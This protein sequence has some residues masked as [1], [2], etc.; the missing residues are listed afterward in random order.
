VAVKLLS[1]FR[2]A[3]ARFWVGGVSWL[4]F[5]TYIDFMTAGFPHEPVPQVGATVPV[6]SHATTVY[7]P[8][9]LAMFVESAPIVGMI[10]IV[11]V[12]AVCENVFRTWK[13]RRGDR[14]V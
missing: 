9:N 4:G 11:A 6:Q 3:D 12:L 1:R 13:S 14:T 7:M 5:L 10:V 2:W 8:A